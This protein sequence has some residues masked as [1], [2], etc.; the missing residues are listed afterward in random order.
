MLRSHK[1][2]NCKLTVEFAIDFQELCTFVCAQVAYDKCCNQL[3]VYYKCENIEKI[4]C[5]TNKQL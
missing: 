2:T 5:S 1:N 4:I 3:E